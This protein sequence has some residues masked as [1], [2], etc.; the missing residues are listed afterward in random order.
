M[1]EN[2][3]TDRECSVVLYGFDLMKKQL[4][5]DLIK[6][7]ISRKKRRETLELI[8]SIEE[9]KKIFEEL[10]TPNITQTKIAV[11]GLYEVADLV[12]HNL[13]DFPSKKDA[14]NL[15]EFSTDIFGA[16]KKLNNVLASNENLLWQL[17]D[18]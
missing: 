7:L 14:F 9:A 5:T 2:T 15:M 4:Q 10:E 12:K 13:G 6:P 11:L 17:N 1:N 3:L 16:L 18:V 8:H